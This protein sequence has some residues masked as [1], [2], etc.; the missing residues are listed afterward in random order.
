MRRI[1]ILVNV[2]LLFLGC[3]ESETTDY[4]AVSKDAG[5]DAGSDGSGGTR[6]PGDASS[7]G[8]A[9]GATNKDG[10]PTCGSSAARADQDEMQKL[11][12][13][14][15]FKNQPRTRSD[16][17]FIIEELDVPGLWEE[18]KLQIF[19]VVFTGPDGQ[20]VN[21]SPFVYHDGTVEPFACALGGYGVMSGA[22]LNGALYY[23][24]SWGSGIH[25]SI[26]AKMT[27]NTQ[28]CTLNIIEFGGIPDV[29]L[30]VYAKG[31]E[32]WV[33]KGMYSG[34]FN[35]WEN[36]QR[37]GLLRES[38]GALVLFDEFGNA[39]KPDLPASSVKACY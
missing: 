8:D 33:D 1:S 38:K 17:N 9:G 26:L 5:V 36:A 22:V 18:L 23:S 27:W 29:D 39:I 3:S 25:R 37:F 6:T 19:Y 21:E 32:I 34:S 12:R 35:S 13:E 15:V 2:S 10:S 16:V 28:N 11:V 31:G 30:F 4:R 24:Y 14:Y 20:Q 7:A